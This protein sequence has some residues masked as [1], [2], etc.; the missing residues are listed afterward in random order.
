MNENMNYEN[1]LTETELE[2]VNGGGLGMA[3]LAGITVYTFYKAKQ[4]I[5][6]KK[7]WDIRH[8]K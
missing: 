7:I 3:I 4:Y 1:E 2:D 6:Q 8:G 5:T